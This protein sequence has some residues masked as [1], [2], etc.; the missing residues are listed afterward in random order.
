MTE[1]LARRRFLRSL[2]LAPVVGTL[3]V[4]GLGSAGLTSRIRKPFQ[5]RL[6]NSPRGSLRDDEFRNIAAFGEVLIPADDTPGVD[7]AWVRDYVDRQ[8]TARAGWLEEYRSA[9]SLLDRLAS[10]A[11]QREPFSTLP[12]SVRDS[13]VR[14]SFPGNGTFAQ[15]VFQ[16]SI[17]TTPGRQKMRAWTL[18]A[19][20]L[21]DGF[22]GS[23]GGWAVIGYT[24]Y[25]GTAAQDPRGYTQAV[26]LPA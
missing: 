22:Y 15:W 18:V 21:I 5:P 4:S 7:E 19:R 13:I 2:A 10:E 8:T 11:G 1:R 26:R 9:A 3:A 12:F 23:P 16:L 24:N 14:Q 20:D 25:P 6:R 17:C